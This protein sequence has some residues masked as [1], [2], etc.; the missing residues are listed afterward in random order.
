MWRLTDQAKRKVW[1]EWS[2]AVYIHLPSSE[3]D[4]V[5]NEF[6][7]GGSNRQFEGQSLGG[8]M[9]PM[10]GDGAFASAP[11]PRIGSGSVGGSGRDSGRMSFGF[12]SVGGQDAERTGGV[13]RVK[14]GMSRLQNPGGRSSWIGL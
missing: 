13:R 11:S 9:S 7:N 12:G 8:M 14:V 2:A 4:P 5:T 3:Y 6:V 10:S 1:F